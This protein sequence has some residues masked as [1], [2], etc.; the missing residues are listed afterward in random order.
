MLGQTLEAWRAASPDRASAVC[1]PDAKDA[2]R[3]DCRLASQPLGARYLARELTYSFTDGRLARVR[4]RSSIDGFDHV[5][6]LLKRAYGQPAKITRDQLRLENGYTLPHVAMEWRT[7]HGRAR[8]SD[9]AAAGMLEVTVTVD[10]SAAK[11]T[12]ARAG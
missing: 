3:T 5:T 2:R 8:L 1:T 7:A 12:T 4:F 10:P 6:A 9:P 11:A